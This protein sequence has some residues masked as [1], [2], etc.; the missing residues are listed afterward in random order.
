MSANNHKYKHEALYGL[1]TENSHYLT[2]G[3]KNKSIRKETTSGTK[4]PLLQ[5]DHVN[6]FEK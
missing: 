5:I 2:P 3:R 1:I 6:K 4:Q